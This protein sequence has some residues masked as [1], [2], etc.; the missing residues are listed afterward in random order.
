[1]TKCVHLGCNAEIP[2]G[3]RLCALHFIAAAKRHGLS[4]H[5]HVEARK[6]PEDIAVLADQLAKALSRIDALEKRLRHLTG[7]QE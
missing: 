6:A 1:M 5:S 4:R 3:H 2:D 7:D